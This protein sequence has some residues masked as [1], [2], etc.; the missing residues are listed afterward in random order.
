MDTLAVVVLIVLGFVVAVGGIIYFR[1]RRTRRYKAQCQAVVEA[2][3]TER[4]QRLDK[5]IKQAL[6]QSLETSFPPREECGNIVRDLLQQTQAAVFPSAPDEEC[7]VSAEQLPSAVEL[8]RRLLSSRAVKDY[9]RVQTLAVYGVVNDILVTSGPGVFQSDNIESPASDVCLPSVA[10][11]ESFASV[12]GKYLYQMAHRLCTARQYDAEDDA[13]NESDDDTLM[14]RVGPSTPCASLEKYLYPGGPLARQYIEVTRDAKKTVNVTAAG[15]VHV[16]P[17]VG[18]YTKRQTETMLDHVFNRQQTE[19]ARLC[20]LADDL[21]VFAGCIE[22]SSVRNDAFT[23]LFNLQRLL[24]LSNVPVDKDALTAHEALVMFD[25]EVKLW[26]LD[27]HQHICRSV[28]LRWR[29]SALDAAAAVLKNKLQS[30][31]GLQKGSE[32]CKP[33][34]ISAEDAEKAFASFRRSEFADWAGTLCVASLED[35]SDGASCCGSCMPQLL[36]FEAL[37][38]TEPAE[39][40]RLLMKRF[41]RHLLEAFLDQDDRQSAKM[42]LAEVKRRLMQLLL[43]ETADSSETAPT[44]V[45]LDAVSIAFGEAPP[46]PPERIDAYSPRSCTL[47]TAD[48]GAA[49]PIKNCWIDCVDA[50]VRATFFDVERLVDRSLQRLEDDEAEQQFRRRCPAAAT[51]LDAVLTDCV[52]ARSTDIANLALQMAVMRRVYKSARDLCSAG[53]RY[54]VNSDTAAV[55]SALDASRDSLMDAREAKK[56]ILD[57]NDILSWAGDGAK[58]IDAV[59]GKAVLVFPW[60]RVFVAYNFFA[61]MLHKTKVTLQFVYD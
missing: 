36:E 18:L 45:A 55:A 38:S 17:S 52:R 58:K 7:L 25:R 22:H 41:R 6:V 44:S 2:A 50:A 15:D 14:V 37:Y 34:A 21:D 19:D 23:F 11:E 29:D 26:A 13:S 47:D 28:A 30:Q 60:H 53:R 49:S 20:S 33:S 51:A 56:C 27:L 5:D 1:R 3:I 43:P 24:R 57:G 54:A 8:H 32:L 48:N 39:C 61:E 4:L 10:E 12:R 31:V 40:E 16:A 59:S 42:D 35:N 46:V 9:C